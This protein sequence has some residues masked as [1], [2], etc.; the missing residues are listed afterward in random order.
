[1][2]DDPFTEENIKVGAALAA[3]VLKAKPEATIRRVWCHVQQKLVDPKDRV[4]GKGKLNYVQW[5]AEDLAKLAVT[6]QSTALALLLWLTA[7]W[8]LGGKR[9]PF[10]LVSGEIKGLR[11]AGKRKLRAIRQLTEAGL[12]SV[13]RRRGKSHLVTLLW[14]EHPYPRPRS[15]M[16]QVLG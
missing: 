13:Q 5:P 2:S 6:T 3:E 14:A 9:N 16:T 12:I 4:V 1:M 8:F 15:P 11:L 7:R 10:P